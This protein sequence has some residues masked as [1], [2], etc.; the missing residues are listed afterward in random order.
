[1]KI[2][3]FLILSFASIQIFALEIPYKA[4]DKVKIK[5]TD[6]VVFV[7]VGS[8]STSIKAEM[9][10]SSDDWRVEN[11]DGVVEIRAKDFDSVQIEKKGKPRRLDVTVP[12]GTAL[13]IFGL[14]GILSLQKINKDSFINWQRGKVSVRDSIGNIRIQT[15]K[16]DI[17]VADH[18]GKVFIDSMSANVQVRDLNGDL[19]LHAFT[20]ETNVDK[21]KGFL[22]VNNGSGVAKIVNSSG[23]IQFE[24]SRGQFHVA[25]FQ[26]RIEGQTNEGS[27]T[28]NMSTENEIN[29]KSQTGKVTVQTPPGS[30]AYLN[31]STGDGDL[32]LPSYM[33]IVR[34]GS[35]KSVRSRLRGEN[36]KGS[37]V[38]RGVDA[39]I[40]IK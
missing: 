26:G 1:M 9:T 29:V 13:E 36:Q 37:V 30:G 20:G 3:L 19:D 34:D 22:A 32:Y 31:L 7:T 12:S 28:V 18:Q 2:I 10:P 5:S 25:N 21:S 16:G 38:F 24:Q 27:V 11:F 17:L 6:S 40:I 33:K 35:T 39:S 4:G 14:E 15:Q 8:H 23:T